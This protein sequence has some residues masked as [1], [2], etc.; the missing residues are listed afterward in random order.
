M[1][2]AGSSS[3]AGAEPM[4]DEGTQRCLDMAR[5]LIVELTKGK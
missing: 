3:K 4:T 1:A 5:K 2:K